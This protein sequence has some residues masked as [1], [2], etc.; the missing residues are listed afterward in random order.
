MAKQVSDRRRV[1]SRSSSTSAAVLDHSAVSC[2][3]AGDGG[4]GGHGGHGGA[5]DGGHGE[6]VE[7]SGRGNRV[8]LA[9]NYGI[10]ESN[11]A[12]RRAFIRLG[13]QERTVMTGLLAW[14]RVEAQSIAKEFYDWQFEFPPTRRFFEQHARSKGV[15]LGALRQ[16]LEA[17]QAR[18]F[19]DLFE[20][21]ASNWGLEYF[22]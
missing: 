22:E 3:G 18:F 2:G 8:Q 5:G 14:A 4:R 11:L 21:A 17:T 6:H 1:P 9:H 7:H 12:T 10:D 19:V 15:E 20:G 16:Q 13:E